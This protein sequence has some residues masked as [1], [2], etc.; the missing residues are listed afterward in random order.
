MHDTGLMQYWKNRSPLA[1]SQC[2]PNNKQMLTKQKE[3]KKP[4]SLKNLSG[5]LVILQIGLSVSLI[6]FIV[7]IV[8][9]NCHK[10]KF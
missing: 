6:A 5:A 3:N 10:M 1:A 2:D 8:V 4:L 9:G 7:E